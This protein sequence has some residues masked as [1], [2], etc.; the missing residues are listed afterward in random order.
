MA[1]HAIAMPQ[2]IRFDPETSIE[3]SR[4]IDIE[5]VQ[6]RSFRRAST[7]NRQFCTAQTGLEGE[8]SFL[9]HYVRSCFKTGLGYRQDR[10]WCL[11]D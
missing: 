6:V 8:S 10:A 9:P 3:N 4:L 7:R 1:V 5:S 11:Y 2:G